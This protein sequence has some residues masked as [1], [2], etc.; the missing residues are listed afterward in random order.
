MFYDNS[1][2]RRRPNGWAE[3]R[4]AFQKLLASARP[5]NKADEG[6]AVEEEHKDRS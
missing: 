1:F 6:R 4:R 2:A 5:E 3:R